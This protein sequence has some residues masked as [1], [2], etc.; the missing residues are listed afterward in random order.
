MWA[1]AL[2]NGHE[3]FHFVRNGS[4][5]FLGNTSIKAAGHGWLR[6]TSTAA[7]AWRGCKEGGM[8][9]RAERTSGVGREDVVGYVPD[10]CGK[11]GGKLTYDAV[12]I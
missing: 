8:E 1:V 11:M 2:R 3:S 9:E 10:A 4:E 12:N 6:H 7:R 5:S